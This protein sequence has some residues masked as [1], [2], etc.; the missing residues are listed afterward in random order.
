MITNIGFLATLRDLPDHNFSPTSSVSHNIKYHHYTS[1]SFSGNLLPATSDS[2][3]YR[4]SVDKVPPPQRL[5]TRL[6]IWALTLV[7]FLLCW[8]YITLAVNCMTYT[9][10]CLRMPAQ[11]ILNKWCVCWSITGFRAS[12]C[13]CSKALE[14]THWKWN[15]SIPHSRASAL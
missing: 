3:L 11:I 13:R 10:P 5:F 8:T 1:E 7:G 15:D 4:W 12:V 6:W 14:P 9:Y 2:C